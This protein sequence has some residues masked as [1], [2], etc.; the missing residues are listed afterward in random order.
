[1]DDESDDGPADAE[2]MLESARLKRFLTE[3][4]TRD[5]CERLLQPKTSADGVYLVRKSTSRADAFALSMV[6]GGMVHHFELS[7]LSTGFIRTSNNHEF[8]SLDVRSPLVTSCHILSHLITS[9]QPPLQAR[10]RPHLL[11]QVMITFFKEHDN[12]GLPCKL[13]HGCMHFDAM[14]S[15]TPE[16][17][18]PPEDGYGFGTSQFAKETE[19]LLACWFNASSLFLLLNTQTA[20]QCSVVHSFSRMLVGSLLFSLRFVLGFAEETYDAVEATVAQREDFERRNT[21]GMSA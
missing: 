6:H 21:F 15:S 11:C 13:S 14:L 20:A 18:A 3:T 19:C 8:P 9:Y 12:E 4:I 17:V 16:Q 7:K 1:L 10:L 5:D 2:S